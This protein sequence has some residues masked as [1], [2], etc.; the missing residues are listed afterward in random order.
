MKSIA[1]RKLRQEKAELEKEVS[2]LKERWNLISGKFSDYEKADIDTSKV[3]IENKLAELQGE[4]LSKTKNHILMLYKEFESEK[5]FGRTMVEQ[6]TGLK[7]SRTSELIKEMLDHGIIEP[8]QGF[9]KGKYRFR[10]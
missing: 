7:S 10:K 8:V 1:N 6:V 5:V 4:I 3:D 9:G 2:F